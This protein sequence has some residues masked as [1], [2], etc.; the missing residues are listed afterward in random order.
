MVWG[1]LAQAP[2]RFLAKICSDKEKPDGQFVLAPTREARSP[3]TR[4]RCA[5]TLVHRLLCVDISDARVA[6]LT[7]RF[8]L[9]ATGS[10]WLFSLCFYGSFLALAARSRWPPFLALTARSRW[11]PFLALASFQAVLG[12]L[13]ELPARKVGGVGSVTERMLKALGV[14]CVGPYSPDTA[15]PSYL[16]RR[17]LPQRSQAQS[18]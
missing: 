18:P 15:A 11:P 16:R 17:A 3:R 1:G 4:I 7:A 2:A 5:H 10:G 14:E 9:R 6:I 12:F 13:R 8:L